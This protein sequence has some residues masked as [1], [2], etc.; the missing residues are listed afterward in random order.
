MVK[1]LALLLVATL[2]AAAAGAAGSTLLT[3]LAASD[4]IGMS[5]AQVLHEGDTE[6]VLRRLSYGLRLDSRIVLARPLGPWKAGAQT[7]LLELLVTQD[8]DS[9]L[10]LALGLAP[11]V[12]PSTLVDALCRAA[13]GGHGSTLPILAGLTTL[14]PGQVRCEGGRRPSEAAAAAG[15]DGAAEELRRHAF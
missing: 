13:E 5:A 7:T 14:P 6:Q 8:N 3:R 1:P 11:E 2:A 15:H 10:R 12:A 9:L 4:R